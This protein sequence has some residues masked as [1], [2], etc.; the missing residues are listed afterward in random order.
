MQERQRNKHGPQR[1]NAGL[2]QRDSTRRPSIQPTTSLGEREGDV[3]RRY[4][5]GA[6]LVLKKSPP[7]TDSSSVPQAICLS[8]RFM[9]GTCLEQWM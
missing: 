3:F 7:F 2:T 4:S 8:C 6:G 1:G 5:P 9:R